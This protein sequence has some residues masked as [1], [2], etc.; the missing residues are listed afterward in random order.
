MN[1]L[2]AAQPDDASLPQPCIPTT[3]PITAPVYR[4]QARSYREWLCSLELEKQLK[5]RQIHLRA[6][7]KLTARHASEEL[8]SQ[9]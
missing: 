8:G 7:A 3:Y 5:L 6:V 4:G 2:T 1:L 9:G